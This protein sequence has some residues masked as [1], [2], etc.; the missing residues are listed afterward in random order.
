M[1]STAR[2]WF[3]SICHV[4]EGAVQ[5][6]VQLGVAGAGDWPAP[7]SRNSRRLPLIRRRFTRRYLRGMSERN[8]N[9]GPKYAVR[10]S[11]LR[12]WRVLTAVCGECRHRSQMRLWQLTPAGLTTPTWSTSRLG[13][14]ERSE[15]GRSADG[16]CCSA[17]RPRS[18]RRRIPSASI[19]TRFSYIQSSTAFHSEGEKDTTFRTLRGSVLMERMVAPR[20]S[21]STDAKYQLHLMQ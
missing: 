4:A 18:I 2:R 13:Q 9:I 8:K 1:A 16:R 17:A 10:L 7:N 20:R 14:V 3:V 12:G 11:S 19:R 21:L 6:A 15:M 5:A